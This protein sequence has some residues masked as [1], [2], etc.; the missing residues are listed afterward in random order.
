MRK[1]NS[2]YPKLSIF[3]IKFQNLQGGIHSDPRTVVFIL[4]GGG[5][6]FT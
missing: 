2:K 3:F 6:A 5:G 4:R 1:S